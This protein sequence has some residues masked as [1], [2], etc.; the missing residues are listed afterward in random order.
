MPPEQHGKGIIRK[1]EDPDVLPESSLH[2]ALADYLAGIAERGIIQRTSFNPTHVPP[3]ILP[4]LMIWDLEPETA[5]SGGLLDF[6]FRLM[7]SGLVE[8]LG[9]EMTGKLLSDFPIQTCK[10]YLRDNAMLAEQHT[11]P[12]FSRTELDYP[13]GTS[14][15]TD[16]AYY[17]M[18]HK[19]GLHGMLV[20]F[21]ATTFFELY[22]PVV[23]LGE[24]AMVEDRFRVL[25][26]IALWT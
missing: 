15:I 11:K 24:P 16:K 19:D 18:R 4:N 2:F 1:I 10:E 9:F 12:V 26:A 25:P 6:R 21:T 8:M 3:E 13:D 23:E 5:A 14:L 20:M 22:R 7:G 17:P